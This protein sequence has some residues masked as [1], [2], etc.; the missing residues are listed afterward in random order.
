[1]GRI[2]DVIPE[3]SEPFVGACGGH[4]DATGGMA[5]M[6]GSSPRMRGTRLQLAGQSALAGSSHDPECTAAS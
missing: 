1:M 3:E 4:T 6:T 2:T 5:F